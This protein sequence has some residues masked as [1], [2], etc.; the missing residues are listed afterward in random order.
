MDDA[1]LLS[2][3][4]VKLSRFNI[5]ASHKFAI[6]LILR[7]V[8][9]EGDQD[10]VKISFHTFPFVPESFLQNIETVEVGSFSNLETFCIR[11]GIAG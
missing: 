1:V 2:S 6:L 8:S 9:Q 7:E 3:S 11:G 10:S 4:T 5:V